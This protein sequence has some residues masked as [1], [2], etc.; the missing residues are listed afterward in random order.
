MQ[1]LTT[2]TT[3]QLNG[4][5][6]NSRERDDESSEKPCNRRKNGHGNQG[7]V[8]VNMSA[9]PRQE[10]LSLADRWGL[11]HATVDFAR[12]LDCE[13]PLR[14]FRERFVIPKVVD[15]TGVDPEFIQ[16]TEQE[17][18]YL[19][20]HLLGIKPKAVDGDL[21]KVLDDWGK[22]AVQC[23]RLG[24]LPASTADLYPKQ[25]M[26]EIV[27][28]DRDEIVIMN[29][30]TINLHLLMMTYYRPEG[31][32]TKIA[33]EA[34]AFSTDLYAAQ[35][36][37]SHHG[38]DLASNLILLNP[39]KGEELF[40][41]ED[42]YD[43]IEREGDT[44]ALL[45]LCGVQYRTGQALDM[46]GIT[47]AARKKGCIVLWDLAH[48]VCNVEL[49]L[50]EW[51][52]DLAAWCTYK[53]MNCGPGGAAVAYVSHRFRKASGR[54]P[55]LR[56]WWGNDPDTRPLMRREF[57]PA[58]SADMFKVSVNCSVLIAPIMTSLQIFTEVREPNRVRKQFLL[59]GYM[60]L[61]LMDVLGASRDLEDTTRLFHLLT[62]ADVRR[63]GSQLSL[64][65][66]APHDPRSLVQELLRR[67][68]ICDVADPSA[69]RI[70]P[71]PLYNTFEDVYKCARA[72]KEICYQLTT[73]GTPHSNGI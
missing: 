65:L 63:R 70:T 49:R 6:H 2:P 37:V 53:Y 15:L 16:S 68:I 28:A 19:N 52:I 36:Q 8:I 10:L 47:S 58:Q 67:G 5:P 38:L 60:E 39:R 14:K 41:E 21:Q 25:R 7:Q 61:L 4:T 12:R 45:L 26:A 18:V 35:S 51:E 66:A 9:T 46:R 42:I 27:G 20:G 44:I 71:A 50:N 73:E 32:R 23:F 33:V 64:R 34:N 29:G 62:P 48:A 54:L 17:C 69:L 55:E 57:E 40:R 11:G 13:D 43:V 31:T 3:P 72:L 30:L 56:G 1:R 22:R 59:T 24:H